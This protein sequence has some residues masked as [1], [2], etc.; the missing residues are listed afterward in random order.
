M[1]GLRGPAAPELFK[2]EV[3][4]PIDREN[5]ETVATDEARF[6]C[7]RSSAGR[8]L[9][10]GPNQRVFKRLAGGH[11]GE[12]SAFEFPI[13]RRD[14]KVKA[15]LRARLEA[16]AADPELLLTEPGVGY[17]VVKGEE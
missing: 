14:S 12:K 7:S 5:P 16:D 2:A 6:G 10:Q 17:R 1:S 13:L 8:C 4:R 11:L 3:W 15:L 9:T